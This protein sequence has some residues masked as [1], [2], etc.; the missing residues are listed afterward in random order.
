MFRIFISIFFTIT[1]ASC[2]TK[3]YY[4]AL[5]EINQQAH[6]PE[7]KADHI[8]YLLG[9]AGSPSLNKQEPNFKLLQRMLSED[10]ASALFV[11]GDNI[12][13]YGLPPED[14]PKRNV[15]EQK[16]VEQLKLVNNHNGKVFFVPGNHDWDRMKEQ[17]W[18]KVKLQ[19]QFVESY[20]NKGNTWIP[21]NG[22]P[23]PHLVELSKDLVIIAYDSQWWLHKFDKPYGPNSGCDAGDERS[24][25]IRMERLIEAN[26]HKNIIIGAHHPFVSNSNHGAYFSVMDH[27]FPLRLVKDHLYIPLPVIGSMYP[28]FRKYGGTEQDIPHPRAQELINELLKIFNKYDNI[29]VAAG[30]DHNLQLHRMEKIIHI[31]SGSGCKINSLKGGDGAE[32]VVKAKGF[33]RLLYYPDSEVWAEF[34][35]PEGDGDTGKVWYRTRLYKR[36]FVGDEQNCA[37]NAPSF[38]DSIINIA[39][40]DIITQ[41]SRS[42]R[43]I[44]TNYSA[45]WNTEVSIPVLDVKNFEGGLIPYNIGGGF[46]RSGVRFKSNS[47]KEFLATPVLRHPFKLLPTELYDHTTTAEKLRTRISLQHPYAPAIVPAI[48]L[49]AGSR[50][51]IPTIAVIPE[52]DCLER[53]KKFF[54]NKVAFIEERAEKYHQE[55]LQDGKRYAVV[56]YEEMLAEKE[57]HPQKIFDAKDFARVRLID[58][59]VGDWD[60]T[61]E[62]YHWAAV[63]EN[64]NIIFKTIATD[65]ENAFFNANG[66]LAKILSNKLF[67]RSWENFDGKINDL[68]GL[69][70]SA[71]HMDRRLLQYLSKNDWEESALQVQLSLPDS[72]LKNALQQM[73]AEVYALSGERIFSFLKQ[74]RDNLVQT[75]IDYYQILAEYVNIYGSSLNDQFNIESINPQQIKIDVY[76]IH[77]EHKTSVITFSRIIDK[78]ETREIRLFGL[79]GKNRFI[80]KGKLSPNIKIRVIPGVEPAIITDEDGQLYTYEN[81]NKYFVDHTVKT[82]QDFVPFN[83]VS[84]NTGDNFFYNKFSPLGYFNYNNTDGL[85]IGVGFLYRRYKF[86]Q[87]PYGGEHRFL[88]QKT[89]NNE[90]GRLYYRGDNKAF[91][92]SFNL[93]NEGW[94]YFPTYEMEYRGFVNETSQDAFQQVKVQNLYA[95]SLFY[96]TFGTFY[97]WGIGPRFEAVYN[98]SVN[99]FSQIANTKELDSARMQQYLGIRG[100]FQF[101]IKNDYKNPSRGLMV[102]MESHWNQHLTKRSYYSKS[103]FEVTYYMSP[104]LPFQ[105]TFAGRLAGALNTGTYSFFQGNMLSGALTPE[106]TQNL[107]GY[108]RT[109]FIGERNM[110]YNLDLRSEIFKF[111][112]APLPAQLGVFIFKDGGKV[113][114]KNMP[115]NKWHKSYGG[116]VWTSFMN[117]FVI[118]ASA[119]RSVEGNFFYIN[120]GFFF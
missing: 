14:H 62:K 31:L 4:S 70:N 24:F 93:L 75:A 23:G 34:W 18:A 88:Y 113:A 81:Q 118:S 8:V 104:D 44:G 120:N 96:K 54:S 102:R 110:F 98:R 95:S 52:A 103:Q 82:N 73:P 84:H 58:M 27:L 99:K 56:E 107:R 9:D 71:R 77:P 35:S 55:E 49:G 67:I 50:A 36:T 116:G 11:L 119:A 5:A 86:R 60:R 10:S 38:K 89:L 106:F 30:H 87:N 43:W 19:E 17:G 28:F 57:S 53:F 83:L 85:T 25:L 79:E 12:Y 105:F 41:S 80:V 29:I 111:R 33:V 2:S 109:R 90:T 61:P 115:S 65:Y 22:C 97:R 46:Y 48:H 100:L 78:N 74:R 15:Y 45:E 112:V 20:L 72:T 108:G 32:F 7:K 64:G 114:V 26:K 76:T 117:R 59:L 40:A 42:R 51:N 21:D 94:I 101:G 16:I 1:I 3:I 39:P 47:N 68:K 66:F 13:D 92:K 91:Y 37:V 63:E 69:N 6:E